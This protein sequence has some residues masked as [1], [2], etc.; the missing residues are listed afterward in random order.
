MGIQS[1]SADTRCPRSWHMPPQG[2]GDPLAQAPY[3]HLDQLRQWCAQVQQL[4]RSRL[5]WNGPVLPRT[6]DGNDY[7]PSNEGTPRCALPPPQIQPRNSHATVPKWR[8]SS[9]FA[10]TCHWEWLTKSK[11]TIKPG[12]ELALCQRKPLTR[13]SS[14]DHVTSTFTWR[15]T[16][17]NWDNSWCTSS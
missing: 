4:L 8:L 7:C 11:T 3:E 5:H 15:A 2:D 12:W 14:R 16:R 9:E 1:T 13:T 6:P 17:V 10:G